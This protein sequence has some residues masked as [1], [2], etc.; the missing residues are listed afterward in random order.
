MLSLLKSMTWKFSN[1]KKRVLVTSSFIEKKVLARLEGILKVL[2]SG[3]NQFLIMLEN[4]E[5][6]KEYNKILSQ[7]KI[8]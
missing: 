7:K 3:R 5:L 4:K 2:A 1:W 8:Y 6:T